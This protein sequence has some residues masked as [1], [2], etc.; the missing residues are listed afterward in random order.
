MSTK[1]AARAGARVL[2]SILVVAAAAFLAA[3]GGGTGGSGEGKL[4]GASLA[5]G[6]KDFSESIILGQIAR[7]ALENEGASVDDKTNIQGSANTRKA[8]TSGEIDLYWEY[9]GTA[10]ITYLGNTKPLD[11]P[12]KQYEAVA[13]QDLKE[14]NVKWLA[15]APLNNTYAFAVR[16]EAANKLGVSTLSD[17]TRLYKE[18]P[19]AVTLCVES[20]FKGRD[21][22]LPG[23]LK[24]YGLQDL[25]QEN[26]KVVETGII[27]TQVDKG[28]TCNFGEVFATDGRIQ[29]LGLKVLKD[30]RRFFPI[31]NAAPT[32]MQK[33]YKK[34]PEIAN[35]LDPIAAKLDTETMSK[36][37]AQADVEGRDPEDVAQEWLQKEGFI[38]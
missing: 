1:P 38:S 3:C 28:K 32:L 33:T 24:A 13:K 34:Y 20:E 6:S 22:G 4:S 9:T 25:P 2:L 36:L 17:L 23:M 12:Q 26:I 35:V 7:L 15:R 21:D 16:S 29:A 18:N 10:W 19:E 30:D 11:D 8:L 5:V 37:N 27:Y 31:Y 14:N